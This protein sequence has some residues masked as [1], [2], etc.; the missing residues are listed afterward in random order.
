MA[1]ETRSDVENRLRSELNK[2][3]EKQVRDPYQRYYLYYLP[4]TAQHDG[5][6]LFCAE[7]PPKS[8]YQLAAPAPVDRGRNVDQNFIAWRDIVTRLPILA[9]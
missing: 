9:T 1:L 8:D 7:P 2:W 4:A 3:F 5:G 6:F